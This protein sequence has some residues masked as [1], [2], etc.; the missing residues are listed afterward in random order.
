[1]NINYL[2]LFVFGTCFGSF[3][4]VLASRLPK[5]EDFVFKSSYCPKCK[6]KLLWYQNIPLIG[7]I[8]LRGR[9]AHC[10]KKIS[11]RYP[12]LEIVSGLQFAFAGWYLSFCTDTSLLCNTFGINYWISLI[13]LCFISVVM[14][15]VFVID[16]DYMVIPDQFVYVLI[17]IS[18]LL[19]GIF[20]HGSLYYY[21][22]AGLIASNF[23]LFL[24]I[25]T[26]GRGMGLG[27]VKFA[28]PVGMV[29]G[30]TGTIYWVMIS[31]IVGGVVALLLMFTKNTTLKSKI[32]FG[33]FLVIGFFVTLL[34]FEKLN[35]LYG[36]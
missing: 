15:L 32:A 26:N 11:Y 16:Y 2:L 17:F 20:H 31:F 35:Y 1:M 25:I 28:L 13:L 18:T 27:D 23:L 7:F 5:N 33:P 3:V 30:L 36:F 4:S 9:C 6:Q 10:N 14:L 34:L 24:H 19:L 29:L 21:L 12:L 8:L 22:L